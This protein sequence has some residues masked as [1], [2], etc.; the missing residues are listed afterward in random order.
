MTR[1]WGILHVLM[2][3][4]VVFPLGEF[5]FG[6]AEEQ[7]L[8]SDS[9][10]ELFVQQARQ[11]HYQDP[12]NP[13]TID[14]AMTFLDAALALDNTSVSI[15]EQILKIGTANCMVGADYSRDITWALARQVD[16]QADLQVL[17]NA[18]RCLLEQQ[19]SRLDREVLLQELLRKSLA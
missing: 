17:T 14:E 5:A 12:L 15:A 10:A 19:N 18:V 8:F 3:A 1:R 11:I 13:Q 2:M 16:A 9:T 7:T 6:A 4:Y